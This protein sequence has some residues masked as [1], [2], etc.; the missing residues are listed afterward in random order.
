MYLYRHEAEKRER[1]T[2]LKSGRIRTYTSRGSPAYAFDGSEWFVQIKR[3]WM[4]CVNV[5][6]QGLW[7]SGHI[8]RAHIQGKRR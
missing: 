2:P 3:L 8:D 1:D 4:R 5:P 6:E 7:V